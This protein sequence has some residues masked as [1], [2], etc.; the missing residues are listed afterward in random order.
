MNNK[1]RKQFYRLKERI[2]VIEIGDA[3]R[4]PDRKSEWGYAEKYLGELNGID[5]WVTDENLTIFEPELWFKNE[6]WTEQLA[7]LMELASFA[8]NTIQDDYM[9][10]ISELIEYA[11]A[12]II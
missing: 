4:N 11:D 9:D 6:E 3:I 12:S 5:A 8:D 2:D 7:E 10:I 1:L